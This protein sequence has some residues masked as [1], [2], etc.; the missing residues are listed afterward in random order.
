MQTDE[1]TLFQEGQNEVRTAPA[2]T[3][4]TAPET[5]NTENGGETA[6]TAPQTQAGTPPASEP[7]AKRTA[8]KPAD[9]T[10][11]EKLPTD[12]FHQLKYIQQELKVGKGNMNRQFDTVRGKDDSF[13]YRTL[14][15]IYAELKP[16]LER[17]DCVLTAPWA[18]VLVGGAVFAQAT[19][20]LENAKGERRESTA[21]AMMSLD[22]KYKYPSQES[23][24]CGTM[25][26]K[27]AIGAMFL[28]D[29]T[30]K[31]KQADMVTPDVNGLTQ[32][33]HVAT[34]A[35]AQRNTKPEAART[36][37]PAAAKAPEAKPETGAQPGKAADAAPAPEAAKTTAAE[38]APK[39]VLKV[40][41]PAYQ[42]LGVKIRT[43]FRGTK[44][45]LKE[46]VAAH[47]DADEA[48]LEALVKDF[49]SEEKA[50]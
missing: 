3:V 27:S 39:P 10:P 15:D 17:I 14:E 48:T 18:P 30:T 34:D 7:K 43:R 20:T 47:F 22:P 38:P 31:E 6:E 21:S 50:A 25:A 4:E 35:P 46:Q 9:G 19:V 23:L 2:E 28:L 36:P 44:Q 5:K 12:I 32:P 13:A 45:A 1:K 33:G 16:I 8:A 49:W 37:A 26:I 40:D 24:A 29:N 11:K 42:N 41:S